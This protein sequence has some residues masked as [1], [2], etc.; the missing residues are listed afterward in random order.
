MENPIRTAV[1]R[2]SIQRSASQ[3]DM[4]DSQPDLSKSEKCVSKARL[5]GDERDTSGRQ[6][7][8]TIT[9]ESGS[10]IFCRN[11]TQNGDHRTVAR[12]PSAGRQSSSG[13]GNQWSKHTMNA[14]LRA[15][16]VPT[17]TLTGLSKIT[18]VGHLETRRAT[19]RVQDLICPLDVQTA[20]G[21][22]DCQS[23]PST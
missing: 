2:P 15:C 23:T 1:H 19:H 12:S 5:Q 8:G 17:T 4:G 10:A 22:I 21:C 9:T 18:A 3:E 14:I 16:G 20:K 6:H 7:T 13:K 11:P